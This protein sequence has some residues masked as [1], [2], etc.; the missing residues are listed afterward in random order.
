MYLSS[1]I[2]V[3]VR[4]RNAEKDLQDCLALLRRQHLPEGLQLEIIVVDNESSDCSVRVARECGAKIIFLP[5]S[6]FSWGRALNRGIAAAS[7]E[8]VLLVSADAHPV[9]NKWLLEMAAPLIDPQVAVV[10]GRQIPRQDAPIDE[11]VRLGKKFGTRS[12]TAKC[13]PL[14]LTP[15][16]E[17]FPASNACAAIRKIIWETT[18]YDEEIAGG[19]D[20]VWT[21]EVFKKGYFVSY[22]STACVYHSHD[23]SI[24]RDAWRHL[25]ILKKN[26]TLND[27]PLVVFSYIRFLLSK[28]KRRLGNVFF[29]GIRPILRIKGLIYLPFE[30]ISFCILAF[31]FHSKNGSIKYRR[32]F[33]DK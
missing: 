1:V 2:S 31:F 17:F 5:T 18:P 13:P 11:I 26:S 3:V 20:G 25:E 29:P 8:I 4:V 33:W 12:F 23:D 21:F 10:Y 24:F 6:E 16:G 7:G 32:F 19:E 15:R 14:G 22:Q 27:Q 28:T 30:L 9:G